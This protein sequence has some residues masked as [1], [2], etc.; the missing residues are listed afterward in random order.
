MTRLGVV[1]IAGSEHKSHGKMASIF[2]Q[3]DTTP[4]DYTMVESPSNKTIM[5]TH[6]SAVQEY[7]IKQR[8]KATAIK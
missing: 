3:P 7:E 8:G 6:K 5:L 2:A 4:P 1:L